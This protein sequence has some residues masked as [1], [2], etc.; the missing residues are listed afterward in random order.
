VTLIGSIHTLERISYL[1]IHVA[2]GSLHSFS[3]IAMLVAIPEFHRFMLASGSA[4]GN[5]SATDGSIA[6]SYFSLH[7]WIATRIK[8]FACVNVNNTCIHY[9]PQRQLVSKMIASEK[10]MARKIGLLQKENYK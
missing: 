3:Q 1:C 9:L 5:G 10:K 7:R 2:Y 8:N 6:Q 4:T